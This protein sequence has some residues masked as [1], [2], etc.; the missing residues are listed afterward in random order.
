M[1]AAFKTHKNVYTDQLSHLDFHA[2]VAEVMV[3]ANHEAQ[4]VR[5]GGTTAPVP[6]KIRLDRIDH[7]LVPASQDCCIYC[8]N[9]TGLMCSKC[10]KVLDK[11]LP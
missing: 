11:N 1:V 3:R 6:E 9:N 2:G 10:D 4:R 7:T 5:L 8:K